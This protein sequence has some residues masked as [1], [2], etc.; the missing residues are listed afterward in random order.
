MTLIRI[1]RASCF[2]AQPGIARARTQTARG[3]TRVAAESFDGPLG[4]GNGQGNG[5]SPRPSSR[6]LEF[7]AQKYATVLTRGVN[8]A[9]ERDTKKLEL[10]KAI[11]GVSSTSDSLSPV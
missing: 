4:Q 8:P 3:S 10:L 6:S 5:P 7:E 9:E 1:N 11:S 2:C